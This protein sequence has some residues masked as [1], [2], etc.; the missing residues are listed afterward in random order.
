MFN[1]RFRP[2]TGN[3]KKNGKIRSLS[4]PNPFISDRKSKPE[5][6]HVLILKS[7]MNCIHSKILVNIGSLLQEKMTIWG[8]WKKNGADGSRISFQGMNPRTDSMLLK[9]SLM[10]ASSSGLSF[11]A[12]SSSVKKLQLIVYEKS[13]DFF[14]NFRLKSL[15]EFFQG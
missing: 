8:F 4:L 15:L 6:E 14:S 9:S 1:F 2:P 3:V 5:V 12:F 10:F 11:L 13:N 7:R